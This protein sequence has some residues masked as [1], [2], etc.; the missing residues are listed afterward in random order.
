MAWET[1]DIVVLYAPG[2]QTHAKRHLVVSPW[3]D[4]VLGP[5]LELHCLEIPGICNLSWPDKP[6]WIRTAP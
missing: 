3:L 6:D 2:H 1:G 4:D 5:M